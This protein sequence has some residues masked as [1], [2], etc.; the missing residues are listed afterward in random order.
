MVAAARARKAT[1]HPSNSSLTTPTKYNDI[2]LG[3]AFSYVK[4]QRA[5]KL[6]EPSKHE[7]ITHQQ[8]S[9]LPQK[10]K[11]FLDRVSTG[12]DSDLVGDQHAIFPNDS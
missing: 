3:H 2:L 1:L 5:A 11:I 7:R 10:S 8:F 9:A 6:R 4:K 12:S